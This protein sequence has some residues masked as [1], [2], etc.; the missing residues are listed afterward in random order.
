MMERHVRTILF[1]LFFFVLFSAF[2]SFSLTRAENGKN[3][4][5]EREK[6]WQLENELRQK[7][8]EQQKENRRLL[9]QLKAK[10]NRLRKIEQKMAQK[11]QLLFNR[12][13][14][15]NKFRMVLGKEAVVGPGVTVTLSDTEYVPGTDPN[16]YIVHEQHIRHVISELFV[17]GAEA[18]AVNGQRISAHSYIQCVGPVVKI[19]GRKHPAPFIIKAIGNPDTMYK[20]LILAGGV[21]DHLVQEGI[22][23]KVEKEDKLLIPPYYGGL[24]E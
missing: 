24:K 21:R 19:D 12:V 17:T 2:L 10:K 6:T 13:E 5:R 18:I 8:L 11:K 14:E 15:L 1:F 20:S 7:I 16:L 23:V 4:F 3:A 9:H 22:E